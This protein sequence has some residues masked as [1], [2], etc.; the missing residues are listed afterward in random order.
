MKCD[1]D[2]IVVCDTKGRW[3]GG[4][5]RA[6][7]NGGVEKSTTEKKQTRCEKIKWKKKTPHFT[8]SKHLL[9]K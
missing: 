3:V 1:D 5:L 4:C 7:V 6:S 9:H 8:V 2:G